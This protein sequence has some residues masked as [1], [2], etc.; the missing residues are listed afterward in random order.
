M[1]LRENSRSFSKHVPTDNLCIRIRIHESDLYHLF[2][3]NIESIMLI[4]DGE[5]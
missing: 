1:Y 4:K 2:A 3:L 5:F